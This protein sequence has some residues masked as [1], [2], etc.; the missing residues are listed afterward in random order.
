[1]VTKKNPVDGHFRINKRSSYIPLDI[2]PE[3]TEK[4]PIE[5]PEAKESLIK[6]LP[7]VKKHEAFR[8][9]IKRNWSKYSL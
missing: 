9:G 8:R 4:F 3:D 6:L 7:L 1:M 5:W 2:E